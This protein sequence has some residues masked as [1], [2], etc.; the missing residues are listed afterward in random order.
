[1][2]TTKAKEIMLQMHECLT[3]SALFSL[4]GE[5]ILTLP[6]IFYA[7]LEVMMC[8]NPPEIIFEKCNE[9]VWFLQQP[10]K[11]FWICPLLWESSPDL[12]R[13]RTQCQIGVACMDRYNPFHPYVVRLQYETV[14]C[15]HNLFHPISSGWQSRAQCNITLTYADINEITHAIFTVSHK[16]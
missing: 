14:Y 8:K 10:K 13:P 11:M 3:I 12:L 16:A 5:Q 1:M 7:L 9:T 2:S 4:W 6:F 15:P